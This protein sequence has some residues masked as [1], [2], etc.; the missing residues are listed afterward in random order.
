MWRDS[1][2]TAVP[3]TFAPSPNNESWVANW[4]QSLVMSAKVL[5]QEEDKGSSA[6]I[7]WL[8]LPPNS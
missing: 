6:C 2:G 8:S 3:V 1:T 4:D 5:A 7:G